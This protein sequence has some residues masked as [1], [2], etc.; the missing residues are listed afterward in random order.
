MILHLSVCVRKNSAHTFQVGL[1]VFRPADL[2]QDSLTYLQ[3]YHGKSRIGEC[4]DL[5]YS[6][7]K[8]SQKE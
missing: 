4:V 3:K 8:L 7:S 2:K 5:I 1:S 6:C